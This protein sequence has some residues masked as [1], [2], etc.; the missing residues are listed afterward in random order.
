MTKKKFT[1]NSYKNDSQSE[2]E[3]RV[4]IE[5]LNYEN[6]SGIFVSNDDDHDDDERECE[7]L[8]VEE[9]CRSRMKIST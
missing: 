1:L 8:K 6:F 3:D 9:K 5:N 2:C 4:I 7:S